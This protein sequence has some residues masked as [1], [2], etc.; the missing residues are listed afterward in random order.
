[1]LAGVLRRLHPCAEPDFARG[2]GLLQFGQRQPLEL[3]EQPQELGDRDG[4]RRTQLFGERVI[5][6]VSDSGR[7]DA[8][9]QAHPALVR[10]IPLM[11]VPVSL[12]GGAVRDALLGV[13]ESEDIDLVVEGDALALAERLGHDLNVRVV[14]HG[15]FGTAYLEL[16][17]E[18]WIDLAMARRE[19]Y[20]HP[21]ALPVVEPGTLIDDLARR[22]FTVN[23]MAFRLT[24]PHAGQLVD[25]LAGRADLDARIIRVLRDDSFVEDPTRILRAVRYAARLG[26]DLDGATEAAARRSAPALDITSARVGEEL[27]RLLAE[28]TAAQ[29][30]AG[31]V[32]LGVPWLEGDVSNLA[33][34]FAAIDASLDLPG[35]PRIEVWALRMGCAVAPHAIQVAAVDGWARGIATEAAAAPD[36]MTRLAGA[37]RPSHV[38]AILNAAKPATAVVAHADGADGIATWWSAMRDIRLAISGQDLVA[39][40]IAPGPAIGRG[41]AAVRAGLL[42][43]TVD[44]DAAAQLCVAR[45]AAQ[46]HAA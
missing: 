16:P 28:P 35:A 30:I 8:A 40:G 22:D 45:A 2:E 1:M 3:C 25:P 33:E 10:A 14:S 7:I 12:V 38:D 19:R 13:E 15:R 17:H 29:A 24:G 26:F 27:R 4:R 31:A 43:G 39:A 18:R 32:A 41:L 34:R 6:H 11:D 37:Q 36:L 20:P 5:G 42:D 44:G 21:G 23:A 46:G 9:V